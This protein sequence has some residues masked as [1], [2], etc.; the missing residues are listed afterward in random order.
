MRLLVIAPNLS[1]N[2]LGRPY[3]LSLLAEEIGWDFEVV[4]PQKSGI[5]PPLADS[6]FAGKCR[7]VAVD[8]WGSDK[9][10]DQLE[11]NHY[12]ALIVSKMRQE[13]LTVASRV[14]DLTKRYR[15]VVDIDDPDGPASMDSWRERL[16]L[17]RPSRV[18]RGT[19]PVQLRRMNRIV[20][21]LPRMVSN[22]VLHHMYSGTI[23]PHVRQVSGPGFPHERTEPVVAFVGSVRRHKGIP[24]LR[25]VVERVQAQGFRLIVTGKPP[26]D[27][28]P[29]ENWVGEVSIAEGR[30]ILEASDIAAVLLESKGYGRSQFPVKLVDAMLAGRAILTSDGAV[31]RWVTNDTAI[32]VPLDNEETLLTALRSMSDPALRT[33]LGEMA[34]ERAL[35]MFTPGA[36]APAFRAVMLG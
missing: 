10:A 36:V 11:R 12:D 35:N 32:H 4:G 15:V 19:H 8:D 24:M 23:I 14:R 34:R 17:V 18:R 16:W 5:W 3:C 26:P 21:H 6:D 33:S 27:A 20:R 22:P 29:W 2:A 9:L 28:R 31:V 25:K 7:P 30:R 13:S 1:S